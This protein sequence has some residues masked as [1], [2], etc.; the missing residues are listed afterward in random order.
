MATYYKIDPAT[1]DYV[2]VNTTGNGFLGSAMRTNPYSFGLVPETEA[3]Q[4]NTDKETNPFYVD[5]NADPQAVYSNLI[6]NR[7]KWMT[8]TAKPFED[9]LFAGMSYNNPNLATDAFNKAVPQIQSNY[10]GAIDTTNRA[11][12]SAG[13]NFDATEQRLN[14]RLGKLKQEETIAKTANTIKQRLKERD[15]NTALGSGTPTITNTQG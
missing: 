7:Q 3:L 5:T 10:T 8:E 6:T 15:L 9:A 13:M 2:P 14:S 11:M 12:Q 1:G 4:I